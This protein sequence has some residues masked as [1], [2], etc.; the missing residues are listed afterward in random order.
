VHFRLKLKAKVRYLRR[1][2]G[3]VNSQVIQSDREELTALVLQLKLAQQSAG[4]AEPNAPISALS[5]ST[6]LWDDLA[7]DPILPNSD[8]SF[9]NTK[10]PDVQPRSGIPPDNSQ[11]SNPTAI[12]GPFPIEDQIIALPSNG[13]TSTIYGDLE[14]RHRISTAEDQLN[15]IRNL[16]AEKSFQFSHV[17]RVAPRKGVTTRSRAAVKKLNNQIAEHGR[18]YT[19]C[20]MCIQIL[21][22]E[23]DILSR[24]K[25][26]TPM[27]VTA[28]TAML[29][30]NAPGSTRINLSWIWQTSSRH[31]LE[32][33]L[34]QNHL[35]DDSTPRQSDADHSADG[36]QSLLECMFHSFHQDIK[37]I[38]I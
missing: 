28:S 16:I 7:F 38:I 30:P 13:N 33:P 4:V 14:L 9:P 18:T 5:A 6:D 36:F 19:K 17:I 34:S 1:S 29:N 32:F 35:A 27:D 20:R 37:F 2:P 10:V 24:L 8:S 22:A 23:D 26:L 21:A 15:N 25:V 11:V 31:I 12:I 3:N